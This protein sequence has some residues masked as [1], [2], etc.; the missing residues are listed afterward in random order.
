MR[1]CRWENLLDLKSQCLP[2]RQLPV[3]FFMNKTWGKTYRAFRHAI[4]AGL[5]AF[6][7]ASLAGF[8]S[9]TAVKEI[10]LVAAA[11]LLLFVVVLV[12]V[13]FDLVGVA[14]TAASESA[15]HSRAANKVSG[16]AQAVRLVKNAPRVASF[17]ND[18][19]GDVCGT[20]AGAIGATILFKLFIN[21]PEHIS[22]WL[23]TIMTALIAALAVGGKAF[24]KTFA[25]E[26]GTDIICMTGRLLAWLRLPP[27][28][29]RR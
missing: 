20:L 1:G 5:W 23:A 6:L 16:A 25:V 29:Q 19:V 26:H 28:I 2:G 17:C 9:Q 11:F 18:V 15:L 22:V 21:Q 13:L 8:L 12:G 4:A 14:A 10:T 27:R 3:F 7:L 24:G